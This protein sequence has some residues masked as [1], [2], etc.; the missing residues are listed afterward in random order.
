MFYISYYSTT[1][2]ELIGYHAATKQRVATKLGSS[3]GY[4]CCVGTDGALY[5]GGIEPG[6]LYRYDPATKEVENLGGATIRCPVHLGCGCLGGRQGLRSV[7][8]YVQCDRVQHRHQDPARPG[9]GD[10][11]RAVRPLDLRGSSRQGLGGRRQ[12]R[13][14]DRARPKHRRAPRRAARRVPAQL[15][16]LAAGGQR[17]VRAGRRPLR[18]RHAGVRRRHREARARGAPAQGF[19]LVEEHRGCPGRGSVPRHGPQRRPLPL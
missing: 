8:P 6:N 12:P 7:L 5:V 17:Q 1:G 19:R 11:R 3:G 16:L 18:R 2:C 15:H 10:A 14:L 9:K 4:G 13:P